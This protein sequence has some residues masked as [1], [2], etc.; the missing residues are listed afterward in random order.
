M[1]RDKIVDYLDKQFWKHKVYEYMP[2]NET[3]YE[4]IPRESLTKIVDGLIPLVKAGLKNCSIPA[5]S[6]S[7]EPVGKGTV[8]P[9]CGSKLVYYWVNENTFECDDCNEQWQTGR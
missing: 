5:V 2:E 4:Y 3:G 7:V 6:E 8:C 9:R 1:N